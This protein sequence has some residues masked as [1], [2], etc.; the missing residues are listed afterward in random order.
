[1]YVL[2][3]RG[4]WISG[5]VTQQYDQTTATL[6]VEMKFLVPGGTSGSA[7]VNGRGEVVGV[8]SNATESIGD[9]KNESNIGTCPRPCQCLPV[10]L[11]RA[12][13]AAE[14]DKY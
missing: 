9:N 13:K 6:F 2:T 4:K 14:M 12:I 5:Q 10:W 8:V 3:H 11:W 7:I 1:M